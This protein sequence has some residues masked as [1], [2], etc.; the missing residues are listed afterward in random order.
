MEPL[1]VKVF[2]QFLL[3]L[4]SGL[5]EVSLTHLVGRGLARDGDVADYLE[6]SGMGQDN[7]N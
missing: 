7:L 4:L 6:F 5:L 3:L 1:D 2:A